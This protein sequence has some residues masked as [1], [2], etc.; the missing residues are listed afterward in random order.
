M[1]EVAK[2]WL[3]V[4]TKAGE[5]SLACRIL[6]MECKA[7]EAEWHECKEFEKQLKERIK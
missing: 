6:T 5:L 2:A 3:K 7:I 1:N 4:A